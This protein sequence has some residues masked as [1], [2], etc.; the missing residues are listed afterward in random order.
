MTNNTLAYWFTIKV[1][2]EKTKVVGEMI[3]YPFLI[4]L[5]NLVSRHKYFD[6][7]TWTIPLAIVIGLTT[8]I[9]LICTI[10]LFY[11]A[12]RARNQ[13]VARLHEEEMML[14]NTQLPEEVDAFDDKKL[15]LVEQQI[16]SKKSVLNEIHNL[17]IGAYTPILSF[18]NPIILAILTPLGGMGSISIMQQF[19]RF[20][21]D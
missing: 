2:G 8:L 16:N 9:A 6:N 20:I 5:L 15:K 3:K 17:K 19:F 13:I 7:W 14:I 12:I 1:I 21:K 11:G 4:L 10:I 18:N